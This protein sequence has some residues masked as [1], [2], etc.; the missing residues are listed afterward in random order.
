MG[1]HLRSLGAALA[2][3]EICLAGPAAG[4]APGPEPGWQG[5]APTRGPVATAADLDGDMLFVRGTG[6][7]V[8]REPRVLLAGA[9]LPVESYSP[10]DVVARITASLPP[11]TYAV[12]IQSFFHAND[13]YGAWAVLD[14][15][16]GVQGP[17]GP[18]GEP[19]PPGPPGRDGEDGRDGAPGPAGPTGPTGQIG[20]EG[21]TGPAGPL[22]P[23]GPTGPAGP[24]GPEGPPGPPSQFPISCPAG[25]FPLSTGPSTWT[26]RLLCQGIL[27]DCDR[28]ADTG[29]E[30]NVLSSLAHCGAC[31]QPCT[32]PDGGSA[33]CTAGTCTRAC[34]GGRELCAG[35]CVAAGTCGCPDGS[36]RC[37]GACV[38]LASDTAHCGAC[39]N[40]CP[41][42]PIGS[43]SVPAVCRAGACT[44]A[45]SCPAGLAECG[46]TCADL[47]VDPR[48]CG[49]CGRACPAIDGGLSMCQGGV[50]GASCP[51]G[52]AACGAACV[53]TDAD[54]RH[55]GSCG[56]A[57]P[58]PEGGM[59]G[60]SGGACVPICPT[61][62]T[63]C[64][65]RCV[66]LASDFDH[67]GACG[68]S[69]GAEG[70]CRAGACVPCAEGWLACAGACV[71]PASDP[72]NCGGC[73]TA[74]ETERPNAVPVCRDAVCGEAC[75]PGTDLC[76]AGCVDLA[77]DAENCGACGVRCEA[78]VGGGRCEGG[79]CQV[80]P[81]SR[82]PAR[83]V[84]DLRRRKR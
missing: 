34:P 16:I 68:T 45:L 44:L 80:F 54:P 40:A 15:T 49:A 62:R 19:G 5:E 51:E 59:V 46:R 58:V 18:P 3:A 21:P 13:P 78:P 24:T 67:C 83:G 32:A 39:G 48:N 61:E 79:R 55:C 70:L 81:S 17:G 31:G 1:A 53:D 60:C 30:T 74:C 63:L 73:G 47:D 23:T 22:G 27:V 41:V 43:P 82:P 20:P 4:G 29:C 71:D 36:S 12:W 33:A 37:A 42:F 14:V 77:T 75:A 25:Q 26:C 84:L 9:E 8:A 65:G 76:P 11:G 7:G 66:D 50:C 35:A 2:A 57:C 28:D 52:L 10:T 64:E 6:F 72:A 38:D 56:A 69:C